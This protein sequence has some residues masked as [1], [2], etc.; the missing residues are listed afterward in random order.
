[1]IIV[2]TIAVSCSDRPCE[3]RNKD[4]SMQCFKKND[5]TSLCANKIGAI[6]PIHAEKSVQLSCR[7]FQLTSAVR[8]DY[9]FEMLT[10]CA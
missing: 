7:S 6:C 5:I 9:E 8:C 2:S 4:N 3:A 1:M 10:S